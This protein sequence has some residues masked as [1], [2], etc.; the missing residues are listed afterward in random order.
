MTPATRS[1]RSNCG[2]PRRSRKLWR[3]PKT[4][5]RSSPSPATPRLCPAPRPDHCT[6]PTGCASEAEHHTSTDLK[7]PL[8]R[9]WSF[10]LA[11]LTCRRAPLA[12]RPVCLYRYVVATSDAAAGVQGFRLVN[13]AATGCTCRLGCGLAASPTRFPPSHTYQLTLQRYGRPRRRTAP[14]CRPPTRRRT[15]LKL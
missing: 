15:C 11:P 8:K 7:R 1:Q 13:I 10:A 4:T 14:T 2:W 9:P 6:P 12:S 5:R 3:S